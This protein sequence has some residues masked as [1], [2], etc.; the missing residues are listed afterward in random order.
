[1]PKGFS[2]EKPQDGVT[3][4][5]YTPPYVFDALRV[6]FDLDPCAAP[7]HDHV[8]AKN[9]I[10]L[11][12]NGLIEEWRGNVWLNPPYGKS[13]S[14]LIKKLAEHGNGIA[15]VFARTDTEWFHH[16]V[17]TCDAICFIRK[18]VKFIDGNDGEPKGAPGASSCL[19]A[20]GIDNAFSLM[21]SGLGVVMANIY[22]QV[23]ND[24]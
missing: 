11:P 21:E 17:E 8:P 1:M 2:H 14:Q 24:Y 19:I 18:R 22:K 5:W 20:W 3:V 9:K 12:Q 16:A 13:T 4:E 10:L 23:G 6:E 15:L 7:Q